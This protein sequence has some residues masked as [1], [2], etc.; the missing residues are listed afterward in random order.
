MWLLPVQI[1]SKSVGV[2]P[3]AHTASDNSFQQIIA[4]AEEWRREE[5]DIVCPSLVLQ[6]KIRSGE[7][8]CQPLIISSF[9]PIPWSYLS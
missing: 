5:F 9:F 1:C 3:D 6:I 7:Q 8:V 4:C 2:W